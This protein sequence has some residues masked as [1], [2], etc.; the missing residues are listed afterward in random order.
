MK[1]IATLYGG[2]LP[3]YRVVHTPKYRSWLTDVVYL[4][5]LAKTDLREFDALL[6]PEGMHH[7]IIEACRPRIVEYLEWGGTVAV[8][9]DQPLR[10]LPGLQWAF[11]EAKR[12]EPG[13]L[14]LARPASRFRDYV[15]LDDI[16]HH[17]G[18][19]SAPDGAETL[20]ATRD[21]AAVLYVDRVS[22]GGII[23]ASSTDLY[24]HLGNIGNPVTERFLDGFLPWLAGELLDGRL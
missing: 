15:G 7:R 17:H 14:V 16:W 22:T 1:R 2:S 3:E 6:V 20:L 5:A 12:P 18:R 13:D 8:F 19:F 23:V 9:G 24:V 21:G 11:S 4:P 10:W